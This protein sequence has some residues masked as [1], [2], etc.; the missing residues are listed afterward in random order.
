M[1]PETEEKIKRDAE[2]YAS[3]FHDKANDPTQ[4][5]YIQPWQDA[6]E[7]H[8]AGARPWAEMVEELERAL[9]KIEGHC[10]HY[11]FG[12]ELCDCSTQMSIDASRAL[13]K[14]AAFRE[15]R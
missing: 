6:K 8:E 12:G 14:L 1:T 3:K 13:S 7:D 11:E 5:G 9:E 15:G 4:G 10:E 2:A